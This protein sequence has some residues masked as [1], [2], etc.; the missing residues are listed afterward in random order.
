MLFRSLVCGA[1]GIVRRDV[2]GLCVRGA[3][4]GADCL[5]GVVSAP[6]GGER[7]GVI[8]DDDGIREDG[9]VVL[10][11][12][13]RFGAVRPAEESVSEAGCSIRRGFR[14]R[15]GIRIEKS[16]SEYVSR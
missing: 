12:L 16:Y 2:C 14:L 4:R 1:L 6:E 9:G 5:S 11:F 15:S 8:H 10:V 7:D 13:S 3:G